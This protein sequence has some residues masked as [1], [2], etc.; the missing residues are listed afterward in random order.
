VALSL[1]RSAA[2]S[3]SASSFISSPSSKECE[4]R[5]RFALL[6]G[7]L[8]VVGFLGVTLGVVVILAFGVPPPVAPLPKDF[9][10]TSMCCLM[11][12]ADGSYD[13][14]PVSTVGCQL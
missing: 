11:A 6:L 2:E 1:S 8:T 9:L 3:S 5:L 12:L 4:T 7:V 13:S 14:M 10:R